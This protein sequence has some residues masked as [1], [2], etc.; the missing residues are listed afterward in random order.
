[1]T[2]Q[3]KTVIS[4]RVELRK[5]HLIRCQSENQE[6]NVMQNVSR[7]CLQSDIIRLLH[8]VSKKSTHII[9]YKLRN[10]CLFLL[11]FDTKIPHII[12]K[13]RQLFLNL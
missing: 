12:I 4:E 7:Q 1:M 11:I 5:E 13:I 2:V 9:G 10:S 3:Q 8:R 6:I